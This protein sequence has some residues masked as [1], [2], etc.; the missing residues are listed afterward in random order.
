[1]NVPNTAF[2]RWVQT[3][4]LLPLTHGLKATRELLEVGPTGQA[5]WQAGLEVTVG[6]VWIFAAFLTL[7]LFEDS[8]RRRGTID[9]VE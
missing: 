1:M 6:L 8:S 2:P 9:L 3:A 7:R 4:D 5:L